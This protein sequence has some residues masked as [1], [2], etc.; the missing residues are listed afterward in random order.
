MGLRT[1]CSQCRI[2]AGH[3]IFVGRGLHI[4]GR[5]QQVAEILRHAK[6]RRAPFKAHRGAGIDA[7]AVVIRRGVVGVGVDREDGGRTV[8]AQHQIV[9]PVAVGGGADIGFRQD[10]VVEIDHA[11]RAVAGAGRSERRVVDDVPD[12]I[13]RPADR[14]L[15]AERVRGRVQHHVAHDADIVHRTVDL[16]GIVVEVGHVVVVVVDGDG[17]PLPELARRIERAVQR[18]RAVRIAIGLHI[19]AVMEVGDIVVGHDVAAAINAHRGIGIQGGREFLAHHAGKLF[20]EIAR[21]ALQEA[22][23]VTADKGVVQ[24]GE[25]G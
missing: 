6:G 8:L 9:H 2:A 7:K 4:V 21:P 11:R 13:D 14:R 22:R 24:Y 17:T 16:H 25:V 23:I 18:I 5:R 12:P 19:D 20:P 3:Q 10:G 15:V 1:V